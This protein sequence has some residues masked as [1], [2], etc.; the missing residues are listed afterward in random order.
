MR[1]KVVLDQNQS[2]FDSGFPPVETFAPHLADFIRRFARLDF[3]TVCMATNSEI[4]QPDGKEGKRAS[5][6]AHP[7]R[8]IAPGPRRVDKGG[9][10][11][12]AVRQASTFRRLAPADQGLLIC[13]HLRRGYLRNHRF[14]VRHE[15]VK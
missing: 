6:G 2:A 7:M 5:T 11:S 1:E 9:I 15:R 4:P 14:V 8:V 13:R 3:A 10:S 12:T